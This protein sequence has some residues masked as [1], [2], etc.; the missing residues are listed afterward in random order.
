MSLRERKSAALLRIVLVPV[1]VLALGFASACT[2]RPLYSSAPI[3]YAGV[4]PTEALS[5]VSVQPV[6][7]RQGQEVRNHL[8]FLLGGGRGQPATSRYT[9]TLVVASRR[10]V[11]ALVQVSED[12]NEP[13]AAT[14]TMIVTY[15]LVDTKTG[16]V[17]GNGTRQITSS[18]DVPRQEFAAMRALRDAENRSAREVAELVRLAVAQDLVKPGSG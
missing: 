3:G 11:A 1:S 14:L 12:E 13:S 8:I 2:V 4:T 7:T 10:E 5:S 17:V 18:Y 6:Q 15:R 9:L 16:R